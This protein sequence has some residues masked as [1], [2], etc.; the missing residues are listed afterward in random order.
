[1][2]TM[3]KILSL[4]TVLWLC[5]LSLTAQ[6]KE[7][8]LQYNGL[9]LNGNLELAE[10]KQLSDGL[11]L[12]LHGFLAHNRMEIIEA[13]Q[14]ALLE[15][16]RSS[17]AINL[18]LG[19]DNRHGF[20]DCMVPI[21]H[22]LSDAMNELDAWIEWLA[23]QNVKELI[24]MGHS[25]SANQVLTYAVQ[26]KNPAITKLVLLAPNTVGHPNSQERYRENYGSDL[27]TV[28]AKAKALIDDGKGSELMSE[29]DYGFCPKAEVAADAFYDFY[30]MGNE[31]WQAHLF[32]PKVEIPVM[33]I[34]ASEDER[35]PNITEHVKPHIDNESVFLTVIDGA[36]HFFL[37]LNLDEA[38]EAA[39]EFVGQ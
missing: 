13:S 10:E 35:Q 8:T 25:I 1:M 32:L 11:V 20:Y 9:T 19:V 3:K 28:L 2:K 7:V 16:E 23:T 31:F 4:Y 14:V 38:I 24:L 17:L 30:K 22:K 36:G 34:A 6:S 15:N 26:R 39:V 21:R 12:I 37:D 33:V 27:V 5:L 29:T 18:S